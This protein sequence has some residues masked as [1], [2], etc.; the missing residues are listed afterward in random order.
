MAGVAGACEG[1]AP[2]FEPAAAAGLPEG[3]DGLREVASGPVH[4]H[5]LSRSHVRLVKDASSLGLSGRRCIETGF[6]WS[7]MQ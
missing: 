5:S 1:V 6:E 2:G 4:T 3:A 7:E